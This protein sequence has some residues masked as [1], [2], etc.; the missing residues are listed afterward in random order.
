IRR[1]D[2]NAFLR[3][4]SVVCNAQT[5]TFSLEEQSYETENIA[6][7]LT[8]PRP[9]FGHERMFKGVA[10]DLSGC[11]EEC[12]GAGRLE[13]RHGKRR[14]RQEYDHAGRHFAF[15]R[16]KAKSRRH[17]QKCCRTAHRG[18]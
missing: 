5:A 17:R 8:C 9:L 3:L 7:K 6:N 14:R 10:S 16:C 4:T 18:E 1:I 15:G 2:R 13:G 11:S 12:P